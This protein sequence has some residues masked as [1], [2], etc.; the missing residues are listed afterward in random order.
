[1]KISILTK[2]NYVI[3]NNYVIILVQKSTKIITNKRKKVTFY[4]ETLKSTKRKA[5]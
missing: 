3:W 4:D 1:M 5:K 2:I